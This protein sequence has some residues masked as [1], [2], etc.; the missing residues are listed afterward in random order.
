ME[1]LSKLEPQVQHFHLAD[2]KSFD[3]EGFQ[4][5]SGDSNNLPLLLK[6]MGSSLPKVV[7]VWQGHLNLYQGFQDA[8][9][10]L[11]RIYDK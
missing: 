11:A 4:V 9:V 5:G 10:N 8:L 2:A 1:L 7:E 6:V 3:G